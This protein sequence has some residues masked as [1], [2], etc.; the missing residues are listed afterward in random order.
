MLQESAFGSAPCRFPKFGVSSTAELR[1]LRKRVGRR[2]GMPNARKEEGTS[3]PEVLVGRLRDRLK[4]LVVDDDFDAADSLVALLA[5]TH[6]DTRAA[7]GGEHALEL[8]KTFEPDVVFLDMNM[9]R[10]DGYATA[11]AIRQMFPTGPPLLIA[12]TG[13]SQQAD[14]AAAK[15]AGFDLHVSKPCDF[16][17]L[18][19][20]LDKAISQHPDI[21]IAK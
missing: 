8:A 12:F 18:L 13:Q 6:H 5:L 14:I 4:I 7:Y 9:P 19:R 1:F 16:E 21:G 11:A 2:E 10:M 3:A 20:L 17:Y 15:K